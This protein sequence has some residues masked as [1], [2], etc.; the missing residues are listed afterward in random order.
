MKGIVPQYHST[1]LG[2]GD[3]GDRT[4]GPQDV[5]IRIMKGEK[6]LRFSSTK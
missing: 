2:G 1:Y 3:E 5:V 6:G 4:T